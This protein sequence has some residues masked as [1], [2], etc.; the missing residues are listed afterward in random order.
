MVFRMRVF[1]KDELIS[2]APLELTYLSYYFG[3][4]GDNCQEKAG[5]PTQATSDINQFQH[6][7]HILLTPFQLQRR[8]VLIEMPVKFKGLFR[9]RGSRPQPSLPTPSPLTLEPSSSQAAAPL[10]PPAQTSQTTISPS[11]TAINTHDSPAPIGEGQNH[12]VP[13]G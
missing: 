12:G 11:L 10:D 3:W 8:K 2:K 9:S 4:L 6:L 7:F 13:Q 5:N 1:R